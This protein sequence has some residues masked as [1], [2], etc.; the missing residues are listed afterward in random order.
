[1]TKSEAMRNRRA[2]QERAKQ[3]DTNEQ[4]LITQVVGSVMPSADGQMTMLAAAYMEAAE[5]IANNA[6]GEAI[7]LTWEINGHHFNTEYTPPREEATAVA[8]PTDWK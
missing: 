1:M 6:D 3:F 5:Y 2:K 7:Y 8:E 4:V